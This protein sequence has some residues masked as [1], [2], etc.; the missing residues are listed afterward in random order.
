MTVMSMALLHVERW[1]AKVATPSDTV[2]DKEFIRLSSL[3]V[4]QAPVSMIMPPTYRHRKEA[5][6]AVR[7]DP[8][9]VARRDI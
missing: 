7:A 1:S 6:R 5:R 3:G 4:S 2:N 8:G 9:A